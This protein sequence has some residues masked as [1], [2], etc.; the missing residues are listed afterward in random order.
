MA[1]VGGMLGALMFPAKAESADQAV[2]PSTNRSTNPADSVGSVD[3]L[4]PL[5]FREIP[6]ARSVLP[7]RQGY[8]FDRP[9]ILLR[10][11]LIGFAHG[12]RLLG[13]I[14]LMEPAYSLAAERAYTQWYQRQGDTIDAMSLDLERWYF[15]SAIPQPEPQ[16]RLREVIRLIGLRSE[17]HE[18]NDVE[19]EAACASFPQAIGSERYDLAKLLESATSEL[20]EQKTGT[21]VPIKVESI[22]PA[23]IADG[24]PSQEELSL[25]P[26]PMPES[27]SLMRD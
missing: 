4:A 23:T 12:L 24:A 17:L 5:P 22:T 16:L 21:S 7:N 26:P 13:K 15:G 18:L 14:C 2:D 27:S 19:R 11:R 8:A 3:P 6:A 10:Q 1:C 20:A 9:D 25:E